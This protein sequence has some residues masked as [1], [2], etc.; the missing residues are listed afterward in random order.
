MRLWDRYV[1][2]RLI[3]VVM[4]D[5]TKRADRARYVGMASGT[6]VEVGVGSGH[7][8][9]FY[10]PAVTRLLAV[11]PSRELWEIA[12]RRPGR[13]PRPVEFLAASAERMPIA[14]ETAD[15]VV[16]TWSLCSIPDAVGAIQ[17]MR[18]VLK[19]DGRLLFIE[20]GMSPDPAVRRW[21]D[22]LNPLWRRVAGGCNLN[23]QIDE[24]LEAGGFRVAQIERGYGAGPK[25]FDY[26]YKGVAVPEN[27]RNKS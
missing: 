25:A 20:H 11:D 4:D 1:L 2:P 19:A 15:T 18:R 9:R 22:R 27:R 14:D 10:G 24:L 26:T 6:V 13:M 17:E 23:R 7:N 3:D 16:V 12:R 8:L 5:K 21:Q